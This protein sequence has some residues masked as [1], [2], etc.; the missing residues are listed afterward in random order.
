M[1]F[2]IMIQRIKGAMTFIIATFRVTTLSI[3]TLGLINSA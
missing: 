3:R 1:T 2:S